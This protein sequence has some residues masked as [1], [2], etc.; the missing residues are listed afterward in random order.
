MAITYQLDGSIATIAMDDG[1]MNALS[2]DV[3]TELGAAF[4]RAEADRAA[5]V[6]AGRAG[7]FSA[8]FDLKILGSGGADAKRLVLAGFELASRV[9][10]FPAPVVAA[11]TGHTIAMGAFLALAADVRVGALGPFK[12]GANEV[13][14]GLVMPYF[15]LELSRH[16]LA[17]TYF[18]RAM[19]TAEMFAPSEAVTAGFFDRVVPADEVQ[20]TARTVAEQLA[21]LG[22]SVFA[23]TKLRARA[24]GI[25]AL[26]A[27]IDAD[28]HA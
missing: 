26:R 9:F 27:A 8:G 23:A 12:V 15:A 7:A 20:A 21:K 19:T 6:L 11:C 17:P 4:D 3:F 18:H 22:R 5:V 13:A 28:A 25:E 10:A 2:F 14:I 16:Q 24:R 1:K